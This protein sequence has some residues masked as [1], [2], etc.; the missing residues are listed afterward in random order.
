[1]LLRPLFVLHLLDLIR[2]GFYLRVPLLDD[3]IR[4]RPRDELRSAL[5]DRLHELPVALFHE[6]QRGASF[7]RPRRASDSVEVRRERPRGVVRN[8]RVHARDVEPSRGDVR[9]DEMGR[10]ADAEALERG[11]SLRLR[12]IPVE[13]RG[14]DPGEAHHDLQSVRLLLRARE[15]DRLLRERPIHERHEVRFFHARRARS[16]P[17][18][19][20][21]QRPRGGANLIRGETRGVLHAKLRE[22]LHPRRQRRAEQH[23]LPARRAVSH[24]LADLLQKAHLQESVRLV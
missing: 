10:L 18:N 1:M 14:D 13:L 19:L 16:Q 21:G 15:H 11:E 22:L 5:G 12:Q 2:H 24:D 4:Q 7:P 3:V 8:H 9:C 17:Q 20:L 6:R 23:R